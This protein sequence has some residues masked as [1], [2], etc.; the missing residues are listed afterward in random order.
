M[1]ACYEI[2]MFKPIQCTICVTISS[3]E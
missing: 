1:Y 3:F 2:N